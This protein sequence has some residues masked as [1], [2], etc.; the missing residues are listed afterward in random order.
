ML[1]PGRAPLRKA[2]CQPSSPSLLLARGVEIA[3]GRLQRHYHQIV[4]R[5]IPADTS[6][7][8]A[9]ERRAYAMHSGVDRR[10]M[11]PSGEGSRAGTRRPWEFS[12]TTHV[13][14]YLWVIHHHRFGDRDWWHPQGV[15]VVKRTVIAVF[16]VI[17]GW[18]LGS[19]FAVSLAMVHI[20][21][22]ASMART[23]SQYNTYL[24]AEILVF[25]V[26][27]GWVIYQPLARRF[28]GRTADSR[29]YLERLPSWARHPSTRSLVIVW[30]VAPF[31]LLYPLA[32]YVSWRFYVERREQ[33]K[34]C[35]RCAEKVKVAAL[36]CRHCGHAF[37]APAALA[38][39]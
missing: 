35:P 15:F 14:P 34:N 5:S 3:A 18:L 32:I 17:A 1:R 10:D 27:L 31:T 11:R 12:L 39:A 29:P 6:R 7:A 2:R 19:I 9:S 16:S 13:L 38:P 21:I 4:N 25:T 8:R 26:L 36:V 33:S 37:D 28:L 22:P 30:V 23:Y 20:N 24:G